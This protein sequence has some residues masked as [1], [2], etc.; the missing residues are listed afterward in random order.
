MTSKF[1]KRRLSKIKSLLRSR[2]RRFSLKNKSLSKSRKRR[3]RPKR[4]QLLD[5]HETTNVKQSKRHYA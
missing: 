2:K 3:L 5:H 1:R 4:P